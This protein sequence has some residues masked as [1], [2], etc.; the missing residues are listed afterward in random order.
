M[1]AGPVW[2]GAQITERLATAYYTAASAGADMR[3]V[4]ERLESTRDQLSGSSRSFAIWDVLDDHV[5]D[6]YGQVE[7]HAFLDLRAAYVDALAEA[8]LATVRNAYADGPEAGWRALVAAYADAALAWRFDV[9]RRLAAELTAPPEK[10]AERKV[11]A[12]GAGRGLD[13][14]W[15]ETYPMYRLLA[16]QPFLTD[17][18]AARLIAVEG[19][20]ELYHVFRHDRAR[21][22]L[23]QALQRAPDDPV[24]ISSMG[25]YLLNRD[26]VAEARAQFQRAI[27]IDPRHASGYCLL[28][29]CCLP[30]NDVAAAEAWY[31]QALAIRPGDYSGYGRLCRL[32]GK[33]KTQSDIPDPIPTLVER[34][35]LTD[36][37]VLYVFDVEAGAAYQERQDFDRAHEWYQRAIALDPLRLGA[38]TSEGYLFM[39]QARLD[40][41]R[42]WFGKAIEVAAE[43]LDGYWGMAL[44][45][46]R[47]EQ[48]EAAER[49]YAKSIPLRPEW[50]GILHANIAWIRAKLGRLADAEA[51][52]LEAIRRDPTDE[53][54]LAKVERI[55][56]DMARTHHDLAAATRIYDGIRASVGETYKARHLN[57]VGVLL[58]AAGDRAAAAEAFKAAVAADP[59]KPSY[60]A[61]LARE[62]RQL[63]AWDLGRTLFD[64]APPPVQAD[65][66]FRSEMA[67]LRN[68]EANEH[69]ARQ[70]YDRAVPL[71][72]EAIAFTPTDAV[73]HSNLSLARELDKTDPDLA[74]RLEGVRAALTEAFRLDPRNAEYRDRLRNIEELS[75]LAPI[76]G[77][78]G[79]ERLPVVTP[80]AMEVAVDL[81]PLVEGPRD[82]TVAPAFESLL[83]GVRGEI[84]DRYGLRIP[85]V[86]TRGNSGDLPPGSYVIMLMEVPIVMGSVSLAQ[87]FCPEIRATVQ[88][89]GIPCEPASGPAGEDG[90]WI[91]AADWDAASAAGLPLWAVEEYPVRHIGAIVER[92]L[93]DFI[94]VNETYERLTEV[95]FDL[96]PQIEQSDGGVPRFAGVLRALV[97]E[98]VP[99]GE[100]REICKRYLEVRG[101]LSQADMVEQL[102]SLPQIAP[103]LPGNA[104]GTQLISMG[105][106]FERRILEGVHRDGSHVVLAMLPDSC[107]ATLGEV[108]DRLTDQRH[109]TL[110]V[111]S[112]PARPFVRKLIE[113]EWPNVPVL[114]RHEL[115]IMSAT[116]GV[117]S[118]DLVAGGEETR[119]GAS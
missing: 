58:S 89:K 70:A 15:Y 4:T 96:L 6:A 39:E 91:A 26:K 20:I 105:A 106:D 92:N 102:R 73:L 2:N 112:A 103:R 107:Q 14:R 94:G 65:A 27:D 22:L 67:L 16:A 95:C 13:E 18:Q 84:F 108:R 46:E 9:C 85:G 10:D 64:T 23:E 81:I 25:E 87:R 3:R 50:D 8:Q 111:E 62:I 119:S 31:R 43:A 40:D 104:A 53:A 32:F 49:W 110:V 114:S 21:M 61:S 55:A 116:G 38:Y 79:L 115:E 71:F 17:V 33:R 52:A 48:W 66:S 60:R 88:A 72:E 11:L 100:L 35:A 29:D 69:F 24:V 97:A 99:I 5:V 78:V 56:D 54:V 75:D 113:M 30:E 109:A 80:I 77:D 36:P 118:S 47:A 101:G 63:G 76:Y 28:G 44:V 82:N 90:C 74:R 12:D 93:A 57:Q 1:P 83:K 7:L 37:R 51:G 45:E 98:R 41:A 86:R 19:L 117:P 34:V 42:H 68:A 59:D